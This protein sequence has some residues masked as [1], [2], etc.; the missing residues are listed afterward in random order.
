ML[1]RR[2]RADEV[3]TYVFRRA[4]TNSTLDTRDVRLLSSDA[5]RIIFFIERIDS[6]IRNFSNLSFHSGEV[7]NGAPSA[8]MVQQLNFNGALLECSLAGSPPAGLSRDCKWEIDFPVSSSRSAEPKP[9]SKQR[10]EAYPASYYSL[11]K[12]TLGISCS[13][14]DWCSRSREMS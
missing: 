8:A 10:R 12:L 11:T 7:G 6:Q 3:R 14:T 9:G 2:L 13:W 5:T 4:S 1:P